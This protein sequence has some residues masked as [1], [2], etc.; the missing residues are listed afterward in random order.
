M[1]ELHRREEEDQDEQAV[2]PVDHE[3]E[4]P[5]QAQDPEGGVDCGH[6]PS[7]VERDD[8]QQV[9]EVDE[10]AEERDRPQLVRVLGLG[11]REDDP[12]AGGAEQRP[13]NG[14]LELAPGVLRVLLQ[15][16]ARAEEGDEERRA[17]RQPL[18]LRLQPVTHLV[19]EDQ[20]DQADGEPD[21]AEPEVG[22]ERD[23]Q[24]EQEL[25]LQDADAELR[26][27][28][29]ERRERRPD[30]SAEL[31]PVGALRLNRLVVAEVAR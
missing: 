19:D 12:G 5:D 16:D 3:R 23:E 27:Q 15:E 11:D 30:L 4:Q 8:G 22:A 25:E 18:A 20:A 31:S 9:E 26:D 29:P 10:E 17:H 2:R 6:D 13:R 24:P 21:P 1:P 7:A 28:R 14:E